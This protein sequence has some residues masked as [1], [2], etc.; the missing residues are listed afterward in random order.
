[1]SVFQFSTGAGDLW[2]SSSDGIQDTDTKF[3]IGYNGGGGSKVKVWLPFVVNLPK[4][5][6]VSSAFLKIVGETTRSDT[7]PLRIG[8]DD[9]DNPSSP[10]DWTAL[11]TRVMTSAFTSTDIATNVIA[12]AE[13]SID[14]TTAVQEIF[15][16]AGWAFG[17][18]MAV[19]IIDDGTSIN[20]FHRFAAF[21]HATLAAPILEINFSSYVPRSGLF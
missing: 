19:L 18:T 20:D 21:E 6:T 14:I 9:Q 15:D 17:N 8:C 5:P 2:G 12:G 16:R 13:Y 10:A 3:F 4:I 1:M 11:N 7:C